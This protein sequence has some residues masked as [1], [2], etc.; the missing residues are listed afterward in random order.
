L[1]GKVVSMET[2]VSNQF[3]LTLHF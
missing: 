2:V 1:A 3:C